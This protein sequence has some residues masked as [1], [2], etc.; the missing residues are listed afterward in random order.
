MKKYWNVLQYIF[1]AG[2][3]LGV[4]GLI[5][6]F[7]IM[8]AYVRHG[9]VV[10][11][12]DTQGMVMEDAATLLENRGFIP[13]EKEPKITTAFEPG[14]VYEQ[15]PPPFSKV[16]RGRRVYLTPTLEERLLVVPDIVV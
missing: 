12:P 14:R 15:N 11:L 5:M 2:L 7:F 13:I 1:Y 3:I 6:D 8:P 9:Q 16:K 4:I 10:M